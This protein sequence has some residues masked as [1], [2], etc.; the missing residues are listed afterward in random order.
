MAKEENNKEE[1]HKSTVDKIVM[2]AIIGTAI[3]SALGVSLAPKK[4]SETRT[5]I[6]KLG[7]ETAGGF[8]K[9][10]KKL[11]SK[12]KKAKQGKSAR[13]MKKIPNEMEITPKEH[14]DRD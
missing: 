14:V 8:F 7:K 10:V 5:E 9:L 1:K 12:K 2:G 4:G 11:F 3:G 6:G 13:G